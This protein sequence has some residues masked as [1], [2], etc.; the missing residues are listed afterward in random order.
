VN[1]GVFEEK[2]CF[3]QELG[4]EPKFEKLCDFIGIFPCC[5][6]EAASFEVLVQTWAGLQ[7]VDFYEDGDFNSPVGTISLIFGGPKN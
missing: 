3:H 4:F 1:F 5:P 2:R 6:Q 7:T